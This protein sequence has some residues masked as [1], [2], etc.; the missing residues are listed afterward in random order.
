MFEKLVKQPSV[1]SEHEL[2]E[3][4]LY[5]S[6]PRVDTNALAHRILRTFGSLNR[7]FSASYVEL[8][9]IEGVGTSTAK[10]I[11]AVGTLFKKACNKPQRR[12]KLSN[13]EQVKSLLFNEFKDRNVE[14]CVLYLLDEKFIKIGE[15]EYDDLHK[16][17]VGLDV[18][19][20]VSTF[21]VLHPKYVILAHN[22]IG[23]S[24]NP[25]SED[26]ITTKKIN[27]LC[28]LHG[29]NLIDHVII[30]GEDELFSYRQ[31]GLMDVIKNQANVFS[32][33]K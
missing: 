13:L 2:L 24:C 21:G 28:E 33:D 29:V 7:V 9:N 16:F 17:K 8:L 11:I 18:N 32:I 25:S 5:Y 19:E 3:I 14:W 10:Q 23:E 6:I 1:L 4:L 26:D 22:H 27:I 31:N 20:L 12:I 15:L 30:R